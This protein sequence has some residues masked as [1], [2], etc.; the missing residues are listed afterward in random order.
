VTRYA[1]TGPMRLDLDGTARI[2][3]GQ[4]RER[5]QETLVLLPVQVAGV[6]MPPGCELLL[7]TAFSG[8]VE[9]GVW[10][11]PVR[12]LVKAVPRSA[13]HGAAP[14]AVRA[15]CTDA[16]MPPPDDVAHD[17]YIV[18]LLRTVPPTERLPGPG[19]DWA[20]YDFR[21]LGM[22][23]MDPP[24]CEGACSENCTYVPEWPA[25]SPARTGLVLPVPLLDAHRVAVPHELWAVAPDPLELTYKR[26]DDVDGI[27][28]YGLDL[29]TFDRLWLTTPAPAAPPPLD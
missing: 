4:P 24:P 17:A 6:A 7:E 25:T 3:L 26:A 22:I 18:E 1:A 12:D 23:R 11:V 13:E 9:P 2:G 21:D 10:S 20:R 8:V 29:P 27:G 14:F 16:P 15:T 5:G 28:W 19:F